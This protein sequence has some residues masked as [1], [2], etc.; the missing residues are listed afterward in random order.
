M[1]LRVFKAYVIQIPI[2]VSLKKKKVRTYIEYTIMIYKFSYIVV[3]YA[4]IKKMASD[5]VTLVS[6]GG[7][8]HEP[9]FASYVGKHG[10]AAS[11][12]GHVFA[13]PSSSQ[14]LAAIQKVQSPH[15]TLVI[16]MNYTGD[17]LNFGLAVE[18]AKAMGI[19]V[20]L[21]TVGDDIAVGRKKGGKVGRRGLAAT[22]LAIKLAST[23]ASN[24][25]SL[26]NVKNMVQYTVDHAAT[27]GAAF[28]HCHVPGSSSFSSLS[29]Q[30]LELGMGIHN[31]TGFKKI[32]M[33]P[34][35]QLIS[36]MMTLLLDQKDED[37]AYLELPS[38]KKTPVVLLVNNLGGIAQIELNV[39][40]KEA[41][42]YLV[43]LPHV[44]LERVLV[45]P[46]L[47]SLNMP[48][49]SITLVAVDNQVL[50]LLDQKTEFPAW[51]SIAAVSFSTEIY[52]KESNE[53]Q[54]KDTIGDAGQGNNNHLNKSSCYKNNNN[55]FLY[56]DM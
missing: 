18:R 34:A 4:D 46:F 29:P 6:G 40:V 2:Y 33:M 44:Q 20:E 50:Q 19:K 39:V 9:G 16:T 24:G 10:L 52:G 55:T 43:G 54:T 7:S 12:S 17:C 5:Q 30:E 31:E 32:E 53:I 56:S 51:P 1:Y 27:L 14:V 11:V 8:G 22:A 42:D 45:G 47:T 48:G 26:E 3:Y 35:K 38:D 49:F 25:A 13:S 21:V 37:R 41:V 23:L 28:N 15:G 36:D